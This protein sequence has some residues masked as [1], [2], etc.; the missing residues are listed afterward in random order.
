MDVLIHMTCV[1]RDISV[2]KL[3]LDTL[4]LAYKVTFAFYQSEYC[5]EQKIFITTI[6]LYALSIFTIFTFV[7]STE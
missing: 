1:I 5:V 3:I 4:D 7:R 2:I 6:R